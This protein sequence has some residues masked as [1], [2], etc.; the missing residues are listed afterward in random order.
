MILVFPHHLL[1]DYAEP[2][3]FLA[4]GQ[5]ISWTSGFPV[6]VVT[7][8]GAFTNLYRSSIR[9]TMP[10]R[11]LLL[12][13]FGWIAGGFGAVLDST[14]RINIVMHNTLWVPGH[15]HFYLLLG[16]LAMAL[17]VMYHVIGERAHEAPNSAADRVGFPVY[18]GGGLI[19]LL[20]FLDAGHLSV[21][22]RMAEHLPAWTGTDK[23]GA[24]GAILVV[25][26]MLC[27]AIRITSGLLKGPSAAGVGV[28]P[29]PD[30]GIAPSPGAA[31][32]G[33]SDPAG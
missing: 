10:S 27:F 29:P 15:F 4:L 14:I 8:W 26:A 11:L 6:V 30:G 22:R 23:L 3:W 16:V 32:V 21:P 18:V 33:I 9:W 5:I 7:A 2:H 13:L 19:F 12:S 31:R 25:L 24:V 1:M 20:A 28:A 17:A